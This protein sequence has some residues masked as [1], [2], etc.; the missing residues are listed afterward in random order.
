MNVFNIPETV[1]TEKTVVVAKTGFEVNELAE[2][3]PTGTAIQYDGW[4]V[5]NI[6]EVDGKRSVFWNL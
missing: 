1:Q 3:M 6:E 5:A 2:T 4:I